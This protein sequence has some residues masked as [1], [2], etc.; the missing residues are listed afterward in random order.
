[1]FNQMITMIFTTVY[2]LFKAINQAVGVLDVA[3][4]AAEEEA[5]GWRSTL[6][7]DRGRRHD[8]RLAERAAAL[9]LRAKASA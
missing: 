7:F 1:M 3:T 2:R 4:A 9:G 6:E 8:L 5:E